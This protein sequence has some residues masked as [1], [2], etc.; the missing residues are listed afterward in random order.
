MDRRSLCIAPV[1]PADDHKSLS[2]PSLFPS[3]RQPLGA[4]Q[5]GVSTDRQRRA[6]GTDERSDPLEERPRPAEQRA[7]PVVLPLPIVRAAGGKRIEN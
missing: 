4:R 2:P 7:I 6:Q 3:L 5:Q 1:R